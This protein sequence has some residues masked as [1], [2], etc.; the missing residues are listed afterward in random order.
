MENCFIKSYLLYLYQIS[1]FFI[2]LNF[3]FMFYPIYNISTFI[4]LKRLP[5]VKFLL[6]LISY[7]QYISY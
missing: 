5:K 1:L 6:Y 7:L 3:Q 4:I 2:F